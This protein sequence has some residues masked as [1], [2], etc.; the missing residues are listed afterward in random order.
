MIK[1][2]MR[3]ILVQNKFLFYTL[4]GKI[5]GVSCI[6]RYLR[7]P[8]PMISIKLLKAFGAKIGKGTTIKRTIYLDNVYEDQNSSGDFSHMKIGKNCYIGDCTHFDLSS[9]IIIG[10]NVVISE[11]SSFV[12]HADCNRSN[13]LEKIFPRT[14]EKIIIEDGAWIALKSTILNG[15]RIGRNSVVAAHSLVKGDIEEYWMYGGI[16][17]HKIKNIKVKK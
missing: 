14:C 9:E 17:A 13:Y 4:K 16:P 7:N 3:K 1:K 15:I 2:G 8:D 11:G 5:F 12:T 10:D 6:V